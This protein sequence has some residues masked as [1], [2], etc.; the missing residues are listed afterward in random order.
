[1]PTVE[2]LVKK[3]LL[4]IQSLQRR[5]ATAGGGGGEVNTGAN[6]GAGGVGPYNG[7]VGVQLQFRNINAGSPIITVT[8]DNPNHE[9]DI[10]VDP[11]QIDLDDLGDVNAP[12]P[13]NNEVLTWDAAAAEWQ[14]KLASLVGG[15]V[16]FQ[17]FRKSERYYTH[18]DNYGMT[19][20]T[21]NIDYI[22]AIP[23]I[24]PVQQHFDRIALYIYGATNRVA[25][26][27]LYEDD[28]S[29]YPGDLIHGTAE[30]NCG[31][32][33]C[34]EETIDETLDPGLYWLAVLNGVAAGNVRA[35]YYQ[36][37]GFSVI[38]RTACDDLVPPVSYYKTQ[39]YG[40][41]PDPF[42]A[43]ASESDTNMPAILLRKS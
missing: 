19:T 43:A 2:E 38:G 24:V 6:I 8:L 32:S 40:A 37:S 11:S 23:F 29:I 41:M 30:F 33:G 7:K 36:Y 16:V 12:A 21:V 26:L 3:I 17:T 35:L 15:T 18:I 10:D 28:G 25:R 27:G 39:A 42:P 34:K 22:Y 13:G 9:I 31:A 14:S 5:I 1:M 4:D 20:F